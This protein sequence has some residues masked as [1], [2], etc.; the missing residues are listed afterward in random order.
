MGVAT[1]LTD[2]Y[3]CFLNLKGTIGNA[4]HGKGFSVFLSFK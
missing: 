3:A 2:Q 4:L 1:H